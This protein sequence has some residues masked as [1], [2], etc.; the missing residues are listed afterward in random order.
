[1]PN[2]NLQR[3]GTNI[4]SRGCFTGIPTSTIIIMAEKGKM[5][6]GQKMK[7]NK[8]S[9]SCWRTHRLPHPGTSLSL[10]IGK[11]LKDKIIPHPEHIYPAHMSLLSG[12]V[13]PSVAPTY[14]ATL[15]QAKDLLDID[16]GLR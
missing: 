7:E 14:D 15:A 5:G 10:D 6:S 3:I 1:M 4:L 13:H 8:T 16:V 9:T 11:F 2:S 12:C